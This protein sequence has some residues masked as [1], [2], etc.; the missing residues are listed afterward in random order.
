MQ[1]RNDGPA[2]GDGDDPGAGLKRSA[3]FSDFKNH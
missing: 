3:D 1:Q 2:G